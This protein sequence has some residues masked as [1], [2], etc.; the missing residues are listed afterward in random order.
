MYN[1]LE[2]FNSFAF[3]SLDAINKLS[4]FFTTQQVI[5]YGILA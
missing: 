3:P 5:L 2:I 1:N 4:C